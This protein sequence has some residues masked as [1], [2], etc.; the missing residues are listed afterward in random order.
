MS[1]FRIVASRPIRKITA[2]AAVLFFLLLALIPGTLRAQIDSREGIILV[3]A[4][5]N[6]D[7]RR[8][9][10]FISDFE[11]AI[12]QKKVP[13][14]IVVEDMGCKGLSEAP[15]WQE[16]MRDILDR[17][18]KN[19]QLKAVVLLGQE[20]WA[21]FLAQGD[22]PDDIP[23]FGCY[24]SVNGIALSS[25]NVP[26]RDWSYSVDMAA[27]ADSIGTAGGCLNRYDVDKNVDLIRSLYPD[28]RNIAFVS[29]NTYG[30]V[31]LQALMRREMLRYD[32]LRLIQI[33]SHEGSDSVVSRITR[34][35][36]HSALLIGTWRVG[37]DGQ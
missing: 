15:Q 13:Y 21:S 23:F 4:S 9:S 36:Q 27:L 20:A 5:Y 22:F 25:L 37:D 19:K 28:V 24:A 3:V 31:S 26:Q 10:G 11:Q 18:R 32:D 33:D 29:D 14:E 2:A 8:M 12:V 17:Y 7:T 35:P 16:R 1:V 30:G 34:L 6:P